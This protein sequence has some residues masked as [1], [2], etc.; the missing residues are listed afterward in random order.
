[1]GYCIEMTDS[2]FI[3]RKEKFTNALESLK[4]VFIPENMTCYD[5][6]NGK[7]YPHF[8]W[9]VTKT[10]MDS[11]S[12]K[13]AMIEIRY[14]PIYNIDGVICNVEF[15]GEKYG[16]EEIFFNALAPY[17]ESGS[18]ICF[19]GEDYSTWKW[20]FENGKVNQV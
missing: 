14:T 7:K 19:E 20:I 16:V 11:I 18:Y 5:Y 17:V 4:G 3:I 9:V 6:V 12:L 1:M 8:S 15:T 13:E 10:V 2:N